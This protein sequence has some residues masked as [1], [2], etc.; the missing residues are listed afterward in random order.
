M[1]AVVD[2]GGTVET[3]GDGG[4]S[5]SANVGV[6]GA[7]SGVG[8]LG[9]ASGI[10]G[11]GAL[12]GAGALGGG[13]NGGTM[14]GVGVGGAGGSFSACTLTSE[15][16]V[17]PQSCC[18]ACG[19]AVRGDAIAMRLDAQYAYMQAYCADAGCP[20]CWRPQ[21]PTLLA[22]CASSTCTLVDL[23]TLPLTSC[24]A[25]SDCRL[26][27]KS[28]CEC[29]GAIDTDSLIA[30]RVGAEA[31]YMGLACD[32]QHACDNCLPP[33]PWGA[34]AECVEGRCAVVAYPATTPPPP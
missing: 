32:V 1:L 24:T 6:G 29:G 22:T 28:C 33:L 15:C 5:G 8:G 10:G 12:G 30:I 7:N 3:T 9:N 26:R 27:T 13:D 2:C 19:A 34:R 20:A 21:D 25:N 14:G 4:G 16:L 23:S 17:R 11:T 18:G 31:D